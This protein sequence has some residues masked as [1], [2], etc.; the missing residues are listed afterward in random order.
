M[1][2]IVVPL[3][4]RGLERAERA[5]SLV[6]AVSALNL[7]LAA[8]SRLGAGGGAEALGWAELAVSAGLVVAAVLV[9]K[10]R[11]SFGRWISALAGLVLLLEGMSRI[12]GPK[13][14]P[15]WALTFNGVVLL[16][17]AAAAPWLEQR[18]R[19][20]RFLRLDDEGAEY[21]RNRLRSWSVRR[22]DVVACKIGA[23][24]A[25]LRTGNGKTLRVDLADLHNRDDATAALRSWA[26]AH[27]IPGGEDTE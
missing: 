20:R 11:A 5:T 13:G 7:G 4:S 21:R 24:E 3:H 2:P 17:M 18:R 14:H 9:A 10:G 25:L 12:Y 16:A 1:E 15:S 19:A 8:R 22:A 26:A 23:N 6:D 27:A